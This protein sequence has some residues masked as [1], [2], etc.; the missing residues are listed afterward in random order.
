MRGLEGKVGRESG[1]ALALLMWMIAGMSLLV[2]A[3]IHFAQDDIGLAERRLNEARE[4]SVARGLAMLAVRDATLAPYAAGVEADESVEQDVKQ[5]EDGDSSGQIGHVFKKRYELEGYA[6]VAAVYPAS[7]YISLNG[8]SEYELQRLFVAVGGA[9]ELESQKMA[10]G[11]VDY[12]NGKSPTSAAMDDFLGFRSRE[13]LL[14]VPGMRK[15]VYDRVKDY[16]QAYETSTLDVSRASRV[17]RAIFG[18]GDA[19][20]SSANGRATSGSNKGVTGGGSAALADGLIT[21]ES[22]NRARAASFSG[23]DFSAVEVD[24]FVDGKI[25]SRHRVWVSNSQNNLF[26]SERLSLREDATS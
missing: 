2:T 1:F 13:E 26:S 19:E 24:L 3:V 5:G 17:L 25:R 20:S 7:G 9:T 16:V 15:S 11:I 18:A 23:N 6:G 12:R 8:G 14:N 22:V 4:W 21:F 10:S